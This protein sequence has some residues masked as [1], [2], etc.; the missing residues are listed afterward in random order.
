VVTKRKKVMLL[1]GALFGK[2]RSRSA[3][4]VRTA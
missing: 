3:S 4:G 2:L 1:L